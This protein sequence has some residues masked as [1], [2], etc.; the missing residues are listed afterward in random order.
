MD[1]RLEA[2]GEELAF[3]GLSRLARWGLLLR[4]LFRRPDPVK[5]VTHRQRVRDEIREH[6]PRPKPG[7]S[8][9]VVVIQLA[10]AGEYPELYLPLLNR[11]PNWMKLEVTRIADDALEVVTQIV[12]VRIKGGVARPVDRA[13]G[14]EG[15]TVLIIG[16]I[17]YEKIATIDWA[18]D[19]AYGAPRFYCHFRWRWPYKAIEVQ[20]VASP[21]NYIPLHGVTY[22]DTRFGRLESIRLNW[23]LRKDTLGDPSDYDDPD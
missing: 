14:E 19:P 12:A 8:P 21:G 7:F 15:R 3:E 23:Q 4:K 1:K 22:E 2:V 11:P 16:R 18:G 20:E 5:V 10:K 6:L 9:E 17:P 13:F